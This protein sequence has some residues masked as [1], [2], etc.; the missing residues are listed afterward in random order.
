M[1]L[2]VLKKCDVV[3]VNDFCFL[4]ES[5]VVYVIWQCLFV[6]GFVLFVLVVVVFFEND[7]V[8]LI[9]YQYFVSGDLVEWFDFL[10]VVVVVIVWVQVV[11]DGQ[12]GWSWN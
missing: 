6:V 8:L 12:V 10:G 2:V 4:Q 7:V 3:L 5:V 11:G 1:V 9:C